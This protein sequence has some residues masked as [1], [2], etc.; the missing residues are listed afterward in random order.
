MTLAEFERRVDR[1]QR[2]FELQ[3]DEVAGR[4]VA[5]RRLDVG[6]RQIAVRALDD[7][8]EILALGV[9]EDRR[10]AGRLI[11]DAADMLRID[12]RAP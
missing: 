7:E 4:K 3:Q 11:G 8:D 5:R 6:R 1:L 9:D 2:H 10:G 12:A